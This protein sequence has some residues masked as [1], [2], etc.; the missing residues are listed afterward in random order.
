LGQRPNDPEGSPHGGEEWWLIAVWTYCLLD[1]RTAL[2]LI[3]DNNSFLVVVGRCTPVVKPRDA[4]LLRLR[5]SVAVHGRL[6]YLLYLRSSA[7]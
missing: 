3:D 7:P 4:L 6:L 2:A 1:D 5:L